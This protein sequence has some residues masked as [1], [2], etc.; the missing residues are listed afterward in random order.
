MGGRH[1]WVSEKRKSVE[2]RGARSL[3]PPPLPPS[4]PRFF[5]FFFTPLTPRLP[6]PISPPP[7]LSTLDS[8]LPCASISLTPPCL[9]ALHPKHAW[10]V[11]VHRSRKTK[12]SCLFLPIGRSKLAALPGAPPAPPLPLSLTRTPHF[13]PLLDRPVPPLPGGQWGGWQPGPGAPALGRHRPRRQPGARRVALLRP[14]PAAALPQPPPP[15]GHVGWHHAGDGAVRDVFS[16]EWVRGERKRATTTTTQKNA[17]PRPIVRR[18]VSH[19]LAPRVRAAFRGLPA[20]PGASHTDAP[21]TR[22]GRG[23]IQRRHGGGRGA[24]PATRPGGG[25]MRS[26]LFSSPLSLSSKHSQPAPQAPVV[27]AATG[28]DGMPFYY[29]VNEYGYQ[30]RCAREGWKRGE[31]EERARA[32]GEG[33]SAALPPPYPWVSSPLSLGR[34]RPPAPHAPWDLAY[35]M[36]TA[37]RAAGGRE[38]RARAGAGQYPPHLATRP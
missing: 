15:P 29:T 14:A 34:P 7:P 18:L 31:R 4:P 13:S 20:S 36:C 1:R 8:R 28:P 6:G 37:C 17:T 10:C 12:R 35:A 23:P 2:T 24:A 16:G 5:F 11:C 32:R 30:V 22:G 38:R 33:G 27:C 3:L 26:S 21:P 25:Q 9:P 19:S